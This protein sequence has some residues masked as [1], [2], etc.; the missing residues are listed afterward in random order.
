[1]DLESYP[2]IINFYNQILKDQTIGTELKIS[3]LSSYYNVL[4]KD[5]NY[6]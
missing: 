3:I 1:M 6:S 5:K 4:S 2:L